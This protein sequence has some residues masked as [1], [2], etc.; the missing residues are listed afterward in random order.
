MPVSL[1]SLICS[2]YSCI[3]SNRIL[4]A[5]SQVPGTTPLP[6]N[7][8]LSTRLAIGSTLLEGPSVVP[9]S[10]DLT[11][12]T[13]L[14]SSHSYCSSPGLAGQVFLLLLLLRNNVCFFCAKMISPDVVVRDDRR[15]LL[16]SAN[17]FLHAF[18]LHLLTL[19]QT[20]D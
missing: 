6:N 11:F 15:L 17:S 7:L 10:W 13:T 5:L 4:I 9:P 18:P 8:N 19:I 3:F 12:L 1:I 16:V 20:I 14:G 2:I